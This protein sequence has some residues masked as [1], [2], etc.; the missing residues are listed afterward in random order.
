MTIS[1]GM[2]MHRKFAEKKTASTSAMT[3][4]GWGNAERVNFSMLYVSGL[5]MMNTVMISKKL[6]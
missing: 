6:D 5:T 1:P 4:E 2:Q 3:T